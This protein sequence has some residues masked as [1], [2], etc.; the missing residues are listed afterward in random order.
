MVS[1]KAY[2]S[3]EK[4]HFD[5]LKKKQNRASLYRWYDEFRKERNLPPEI[6]KVISESIDEKED[7][8]NIINQ[9]RD[10]RKSDS[11]GKPVR[12]DAYIINP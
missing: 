7:W 1:R 5:Q 8:V 11:V 9:V 10:L 3:S 12:T 6:R 2:L 4:F